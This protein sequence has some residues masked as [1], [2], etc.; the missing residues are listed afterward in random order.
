MKIPT[1]C[2]LWFGSPFVGCYKKK[3]KNKKNNLELK[4]QKV[5]LTSSHELDSVFIFCCL[6]TRFPV[7][8]IEVVLLLFTPDDNELMEAIVLLIMPPFD[9]CCCELL[10]LLLLIFWEICA[11][12]TGEVGSVL[13]MVLFED[14][15]R[16]AADA[17][18]SNRPVDPVLYNC[19]LFTW[20]TICWTLLLEFDCIFCCCCDSS[21]CCWCCCFWIAEEV[22]IIDDGIWLWNERKNKVK[23]C[24]KN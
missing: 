1:T 14:A 22:A 3:Y 13:M 17:R 4:K 20:P 8:V 16:T 11:A 19:L 9:I 21:F 5:I 23:I 7:V 2:Q 12:A 10:K 15:W 6:T 18:A 24:S